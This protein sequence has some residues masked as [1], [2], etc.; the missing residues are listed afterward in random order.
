MIET[1]KEVRTV[2][3]AL[4][5]QKASQISDE[6]FKAFGPPSGKFDGNKDPGGQFV[7]GTEYDAWKLRQREADS[8]STDKSLASVGVGRAA[9]LV[10]QAREHLVEGRLSGYAA[11]VERRQNEREK[12]RI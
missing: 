1:I 8:L 9:I 10:S 4:A 3:D 2:G 7:N 11:S 12:A 5:E 6:A